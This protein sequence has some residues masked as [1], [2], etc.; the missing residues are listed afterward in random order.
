MRTTRLLVVSTLLLMGLT[1]MAQ[2]MT[3]LPN[4]TNTMFSLAEGAGIESNSYGTLYEDNGY[5]R[6]F[7][8]KTSRV[9]YTVENSAGE[10]RSVYLSDYKPVV[11]DSVIDVIYPIL[12]KA[13]AKKKKEVKKLQKKREKYMKNNPDEIDRLGGNMRSVRINIK[14]VKFM[15]ASRSV[16]LFSDYNSDFWEKM[17]QVNDIIHSYVRGYSQEDVDEMTENGKFSLPFKIKIYKRQ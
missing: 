12:K 8:Q 13:V 10:K 16:D 4:E 11:S 6:I 9:A 14:D 17:K 7:T 2:K 5:L 15:Y 1:A 3:L